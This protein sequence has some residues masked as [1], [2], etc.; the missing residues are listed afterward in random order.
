MA[1]VIETLAIKLI[2]DVADYE[3]KMNGAAKKIDDFG[4]KMQ[5]TGAKVRSIGSTMTASVTQPLLEM[6]N[7]AVEAASDMAESMSKVNVVFDESADAIIDWSEDSAEAFGQSQQQAL[8]AVGTFGNLFDA[9]GIGVDK[10]AEMSMGIVE[11]ASDLASFN[12]IDPTEALEKLR[13]GLVGETEPLRTLGVNLSAAAVEA[14]AFQMGLVDV[15]IDMEKVNRATLNLEKAQAA[16]AK[17]LKEHGEGSLEYRDAMQK[18]AEAETKLQDALAGS[19]VELTAAQK[20]QAAYALILEQTKNAQGDFARTSDGLANQQR[21]LNAEWENAQAQLGE[22]L[23]PLKLQ[24]VGVLR[25]LLD[26]FNNLSPATQ[27]W[28]LKIAGI[29]AVVGPVL[30]VLGTLISSI[31]SLISMFAG[32]GPAIGSVTTAMGGLSGGL[33]VLAAA[34]PLFALAWYN[35]WFGIRDQTNLILADMQT[36][37]SKWA[38]WMGALLD[39]SLQAWAHTFNMGL[40]LIRGDWGSA[41][42]EM[43]A[44]L[45]F[46]VEWVK[47]IYRG[48][49][50][51]LENITATITKK[52]RSI[53]QGNTEGIAEDTNTGLKKFN[54]L[55]RQQMQVLEQFLVTMWNVIRRI[56]S[57]AGALIFGDITGMWDD[58]KLATGA[59]MTALGE[60][61]TNGT[62]L[63]ERITGQS[64]AGIQE[65]F[66]QAWARITASVIG[67]MEEIQ[68]T[69]QRVME[70]IKGFFSPANWTGIGSGMVSGIVNGISGGAGAIADAA[71]NA[72]NTALASA[73][74]A[75]GIASPSKEG[76][77][78]GENFS[79]S[80]GGGAKR[81][82]SRLA[83][84]VLDGLNAAVG[85]INANMATAGAGGGLHGNLTINMPMTFVGNPDRRE[86]EAGVSSGLDIILDG[87]RQVGLR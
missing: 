72:A 19:N 30:V 76:D 84:N 1:N 10:S 3:Q 64:M 17:A 24:L 74:S 20:A 79:L 47:T 40:A 78:I 27:D 8:E 55:Y 60:L 42:T 70:T 25:D 49:M 4:D 51:V 53:W 14:K 36:S 6:A 13:A 34:I 38:Q 87:L 21:I 59:F 65:A 7:D 83:D 44:S 82:L 39:Q 57:A 2:G 73:K 12:N 77:A 35:N 52:I 69:I 75:L 68:N 86:V 56:F 66:T 54:D 81:G 45:A 58:I 85:S 43:Q 9:M 18:V 5:A 63:I 32:I 33:V 67:E 71:A 50:E 48:A 16:A 11:L 80:I 31:G 28:I 26:R 29:A 22:K 62:G 37:T 41:W 15:S 23:L 61:F 46:F